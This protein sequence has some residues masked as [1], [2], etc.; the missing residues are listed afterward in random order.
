MTNVGN[1][2]KWLQENGWPDNRKWKARF[3]NPNTGN[4]RDEKEG[5]GRSTLA[6]KISELKKKMTSDDY[7][8]EVSIDFFMGK[9]EPHGNIYTNNKGVSFKGDISK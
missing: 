6:M 8:N 5:T 9:N 1:I 3:F 7:K 2:E 4:S